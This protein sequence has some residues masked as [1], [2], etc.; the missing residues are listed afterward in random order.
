MS[1]TPT[2][3]TEQRRTKRRYACELYPHSEDGESRDLATEVPYRIAHAIGMSSGTREWHELI[4]QG[5]DAARAAYDRTVP[6]LEAVTLALLAV[7]LHEGLTG[8][9]AWHSATRWAGDEA[10]EVLWGA[11]AQYG[12]PLHDIKPYPIRGEA[13]THE[14]WSEM[15]SRGWR[16][17][18]DL[19][20]PGP[21]SSC[22]QCTE[23]ENEEVAD[24]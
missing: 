13:T 23:P 8:Q 17:S 16:T 11:A 6:F 15:N 18:I 7:A 10:G 9:A 3:T 5:G 12:V 22:E 4:D 19:R 1:D 14:H 2:P 24:V 20:V 21:E